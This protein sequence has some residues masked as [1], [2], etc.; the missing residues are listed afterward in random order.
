VLEA[1]MAPMISAAILA[2]QNDLEPQL[3]NTVLGFVLSLVTVS[4]ADSLLGL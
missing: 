2:E 1:A 4:L 3:V